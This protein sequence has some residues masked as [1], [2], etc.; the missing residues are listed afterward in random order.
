VNITPIL[1]GL[2]SLFTSYA[3]AISDSVKAAAVEK[4]G[5]G[6]APHALLSVAL[7]NPETGGIVTASTVALKS[8]IPV[9]PPATTPTKIAKKKYYTQSFEPLDLTNEDDGCTVFAEGASIINL[10]A[11]PAPGWRC[12]VRAQGNNVS[13]NGSILDIAGGQTGLVISATSHV[14]VC[15]MSNSYVTLAKFG[16]VQYVGGI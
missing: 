8:E 16:D 10:P 1:Q 14:E 3:T 5:S 2:T 4:V 13:V 6:P 9:V 15:E 12:V 7:V 11:E